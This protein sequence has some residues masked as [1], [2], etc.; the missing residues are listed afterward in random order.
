MYTALG[1]NRF[2]KAILSIFAIFFVGLVWIVDGA[3]SFWAAVRMLGF[4]VS[5]FIILIYLLLGTQWY[6]SPWRI[7]WRKFPILN[8]LL[9]PDLNGVWFG[10]TNSNW[11]VISVLREAASDDVKIDLH[12]LDEVELLEDLVAMNIK[13]TLFSIFITSKLPSTGGESN[14]IT[15][16]ADK[17]FDRNVFILSYLYKQATPEPKST[18]ESMHVGAATLEI[19]PSDNSTMKGQYWT[20][21]KWREGMNTAGIIEVAHVSDKHLPATEDLLEFAKNNAC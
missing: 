20:R 10:T 2:A 19:N 7:L 8:Q 18:D 16:R 9:Y 15:Y 11:P 5:A 14:T 4:S 1:P 6:W 3:A 12:K 21:R 13:S 17:C